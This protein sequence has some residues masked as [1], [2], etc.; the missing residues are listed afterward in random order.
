MHIASFMQLLILTYLHFLY[1][2][3][4]LILQYILALRN[5]G[6]LWFLI[7]MYRIAPDVMQ[8]KHDAKYK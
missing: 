5:I 4:V 1:L 8:L 2:A 3:L 6:G 7:C